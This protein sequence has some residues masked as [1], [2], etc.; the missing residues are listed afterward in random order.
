MFEGMIRFH[1]LLC[2][3]IVRF[4]TGPPPTLQLVQVVCTLVQIPL[5]ALFGSSE[6]DYMVACGN[7]FRS[8]PLY[9]KIM[10]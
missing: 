10:C 5:V 2:T 3:P 7:Y 8:D 9:G 6:S 1:L 4:V